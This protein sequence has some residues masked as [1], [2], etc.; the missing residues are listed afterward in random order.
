MS[1]GV[2]DV[3]IMPNLYSLSALYNESNEKKIQGFLRELNI[4][5]VHFLNILN[6]LPGFIWIIH[7]LSLDRE[8]HTDVPYD[9]IGPFPSQYFGFIIKDLLIC[10]LTINNFY[11]TMMLNN[12]LTSELNL[13]NF[14]V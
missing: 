11:V 14:E 9:T 13:I 8:N 3:I 10:L 2:S 6:K 5:I 1:L 12:V 7:S 4:L